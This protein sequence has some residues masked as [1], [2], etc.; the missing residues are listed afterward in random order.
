MIT[1]PGFLYVCKNPK[2]FDTVEIFASLPIVTLKND[3]IFGIATKKIFL[4]VFR[5]KEH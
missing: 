2:I 4:V 5:C 1:H 3:G